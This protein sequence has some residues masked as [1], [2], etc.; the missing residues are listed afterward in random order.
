MKNKLIFNI[1]LEFKSDENVK[2]DSLLDENA[3]Q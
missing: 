1:N 3:E 2:F